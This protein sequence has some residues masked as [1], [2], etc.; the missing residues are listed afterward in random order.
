MKYILALALATVCWSQPTLDNSASLGSSS[1]A[2][3]TT[4]N[5][6][7]GSGSNG[8][9][10]LGLTQGNSCASTGASW[11]GTTMTLLYFS[12]APCTVWYGLANPTS[13]SHTFNITSGGGT[14]INAFAI[15]Y[16]GAGSVNAHVVSNTSAGGGSAWPYVL[17]VTTTVVNTKL[18]EIATNA[19]WTADSGGTIEVSSGMTVVVDKT[20]SA[21][22]A[23]TITV[24]AAYSGGASISAV[25]VALAPNGGSGPFTYTATASNGD[26]SSCTIT[27]V[28]G[29]L[30]VLSYSCNSTLSGLSQSD[31]IS[32]AGTG[33]GYGATTIGGGDVLCIVGTNGTGSAVTINNIVT[34]ADSATI[35][36]SVNVRT[37]PPSGPVTGNTLLSTQ[38]VTWP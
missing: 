19:S 2:S 15:S 5:Y 14:N 30:P 13:G 31:T 25:V 1:N 33:T 10:L 16:V 3:F 8:Y 21:S 26:G 32:Q 23:N 7:M 12:N 22:G 27:K 11:N 34:P 4:G 35:S 9:L 18:V 37:P 24:D 28:A 17:S 29:A 20:A 6:T 38:T 36:C